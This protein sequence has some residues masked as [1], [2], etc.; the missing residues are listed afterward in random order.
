MTD[1]SNLNR[2][3]RACADLHQKG[4]AVTFTA[5][6]THTRLGGTTLYR[7]STIRA[8]I[9]EHRRQAASNST[10]IGLTDE[11]ATLS[12]M[13]ETLAARVRHHEEQL[14]KLVSRNS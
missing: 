14:R 10:L 5:V 1:T 8:I 2:V 7:D 9:E 3:E 12:A 6:A 11:I 4:Q 13:M